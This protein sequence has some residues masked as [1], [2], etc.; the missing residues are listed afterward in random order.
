MELEGSKERLHLFQANL[1]ED[2]SFDYAID[3]CEGVFHAAS[4][5]LFS[6]IDPQVNLTFLYPIIWML[7]TSGKCR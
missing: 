6:V 1:N 3:G 2:G 5:V 7:S 4:P